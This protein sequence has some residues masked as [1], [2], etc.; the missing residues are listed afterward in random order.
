MSS[1]LEK[2]TGPLVKILLICLV[3]VQPYANSVDP[4][5]VAMAILFFLL[6]FP[7]FVS[8]VLTKRPMLEVL[9]FLPILAISVAVGALNGHIPGDIVRGL[10]PYA[11]Y[12]VT[13]GAIVAMKPVSRLEL[14]RWY[15]IVATLIS[16]KTLVILGL[17]G[18]TPSDIAGGVRATFFD[19]NSG[20]PIAMLAIPF[21]FVCFSNPWV[22]ATLLVI[23]TS[24]ILL[25]Q[26]KALM[27]IT[28][29]FYLVF[30]TIYTPSLKQLGS[31]ATASLIKLL[32]VI[33]L[34][35]VTT[36]TFS[37]NPL[38][39]RFINAVT[40]P[41]I[42]L[43]GR[44]YEMGNSIRA[45]E[46]NPLLGRG[47][48]YIFVHKSAASTEENP[49]F[50]ERRYTHSVFFY[51]LATMGILGMPFALLMFYGPLLYLSAAQVNRLISPPESIKS[52]I[53]QFKNYYVPTI[54]AATGMLLFNLVSA[55]YKNPQSLVI[56]ALI[57]AVIFC[58]L[59][60]AKNSQT[61]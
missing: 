57:N 17:N 56:L 11:I 44:I 32:I 12:I 24:Q 20:L 25:G 14:L 53:R 7:A 42:E 52:P 58:L 55:S 5:V 46:E 43:S 34:V 40:N 28:A 35:T 39:Q 45:I 19:I 50:E 47:Q 1:S 9:V 49:V 59:S 2:I 54:L 22:Q 6:S 31:R 10:I 23:L 61:E 3:F 38:V 26:S 15:V 8:L 60:A 29:V 18:V 33:S 21:V 37:A 41:G 36:L 13:F 16:L 4:M 27:A 48:G 30:L 51:H